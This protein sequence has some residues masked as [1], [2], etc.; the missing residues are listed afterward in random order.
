MSNRARVHVRT[1]DQGG[2]LLTLSASEEREYLALA[3]QGL[4]KA[5]SWT[6]CVFCVY[7][8]MDCSRCV[9]IDECMDYQNAVRDFE[10]SP[11]PH[12]EMLAIRAAYL[13]AMSRGWHADLD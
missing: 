4:K 13:E 5:G 8:R 7:Y 12:W 6:R 10:H 1:R 2:R 11:Y 3:R 9:A